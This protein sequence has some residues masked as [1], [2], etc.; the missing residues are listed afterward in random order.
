MR[1]HGI[2]MTMQGGPTELYGMAAPE[3]FRVLV[4]TKCHGFEFARVISETKLFT[5]CSDGSYME[6]V[7]SP[8]IERTKDNGIC[9]N[10]PDP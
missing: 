9:G 10:S 4:W 3:W 1:L 6:T 8:P 7:A 2:R 5:I